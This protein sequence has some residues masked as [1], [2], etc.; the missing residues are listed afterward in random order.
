MNRILFILYMLLPVLGFGQITNANP[1]LAIGLHGDK[2]IKTIDIRTFSGRYFLLNDKN[3]TLK[4][5]TAD[6]KLTF[7]V[8]DWKLVLKSDTNSNSSS[9]YTLQAIDTTAAF[10]IETPAVKQTP[11]Y[12][13]GLRIAANAGKIKLVNYVL[14]E[15]YVDDV[16]HAEV[17]KDHTLELY[18]VQATI[19]RTYALTNMGKHKA[20]FFNLCDKVHCQVY[21]GHGKP[22]N[23]IDSAVALTRGEVIVYNNKI[24][25]A[26]FHANCGGQT[27]NSEDVWNHPVPYLRSVTDSYCLRSP[28]AYWEK[29]IK[30]DEWTKYFMGIADVKLT[31]KDT[32]IFQ[33]DQPSRM[34]YFISKNKKIPLRQMRTDLKL[35][36]TFFSVSKSGN[37]IILCGKGYGHGVG[38]CQEGASVMTRKGYDYKQIISF[39]F[40]GV[41]IVPLSSL[42]VPNK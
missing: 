23:A 21:N 5:L 30:A 13:G 2:V 18:K 6:D 12:D 24:I 4:L 17:G 33:F 37:D 10:S 11:V 28:G 35:R 19:S 36:S 32:L 27:V 8:K 15:Q 34:L 26:A 9:Y 31:D 41:N 39:Y 29:C 25:D 7:T 40:K 38:L 14:L 22:N 16:L 3:D 42:I 20:D 1:Q